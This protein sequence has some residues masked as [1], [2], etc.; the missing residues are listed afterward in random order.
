MWIKWSLAL[1]CLKKQVVNLG[2]SPHLHM[3]K[4]INDMG[5]GDMLLF[6]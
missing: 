5:D 4:Q 2:R 6:A 1:S 3:K